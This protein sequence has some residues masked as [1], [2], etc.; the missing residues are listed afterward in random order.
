MCIQSIK[1]EL[2]IINAYMIDKYIAIGFV[3]VMY[4]S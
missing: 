2:G 3:F 4:S 1:F